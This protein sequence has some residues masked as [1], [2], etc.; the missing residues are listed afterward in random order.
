L[1]FD[2]IQL[3]NYQDGG[4]FR[5]GFLMS[6]ARKLG[7][8]LAVGALYLGVTGGNL[9]PQDARAERRNSEEMSRLT[10]ER[11]DQRYRDAEGVAGRFAL[12]FLQD[13]T[14]PEQVRVGTMEDGDSL[15]GWGHRLI[16]GR[17]S[18]TPFGGHCFDE[19]DFDTREG[20]HIPEPDGET[21]L[22]YPDPDG[23]FE[24]PLEFTLSETNDDNWQPTNQYTFDRLVQHGCEPWYESPEQTYIPPGV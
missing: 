12:R 2:L 5:R 11:I 16:W 18:G 8:G 17:N 22:V 14:E 1:K 19:S 24:A 15:W 20:A 7:V 9:N 3:T 4:R 10:Q 13:E 6:A 21:V 23:E